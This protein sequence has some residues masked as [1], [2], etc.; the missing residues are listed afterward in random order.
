VS[1]SRTKGATNTGCA[2]NCGACN[3]CVSALPYGASCASSCAKVAECKELYGI[4]GS[5]GACRFV[6]SEF[7]KNAALVCENPERG[8][9]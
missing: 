6:P 5:E 9:A 4:T 8:W 2:D 7:T 3:L 1:R